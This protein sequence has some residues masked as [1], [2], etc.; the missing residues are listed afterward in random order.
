MYIPHL[1]SG[2]FML[3]DVVFCSGQTNIQLSRLD[4]QGID[5]PLQCHR[6]IISVIALSFALNDTIKT[7]L[8]PVVSTCM[9]MH[10]IKL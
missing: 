5:Q 8:N 4:L 3:L 7:L 10:R 1:C 2:G 9:H 6:L